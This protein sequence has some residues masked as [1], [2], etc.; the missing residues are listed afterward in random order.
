MKTVTCP[1]GRT[2][3]LNGY[4][5]PI[6]DLLCKTEG[7]CF[8]SRECVT[9]YKN[10]IHAKKAV[11]RAF[12]NTLAKRG[13]SVIEFMGTCCSGWKMTPHDANAW[14]DERMK[15]MKMGTL[16]ALDKKMEAHPYEAP[17]QENIGDRALRF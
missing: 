7:T 13:T 3:E 15:S 14:L 2:V 16:K 9:S 8:V 10:V 12:E 4:P 5:L 6:T 1:D 11:R 17:A